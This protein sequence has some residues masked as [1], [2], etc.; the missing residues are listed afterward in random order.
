MF[1]FIIVFLLNI[2]FKKEKNKRWFV[3]SSLS[4]LVLLLLFSASLL[5]VMIVIRFSL[6]RSFSWLM[7]RICL[8]LEAN[9]IICY[10]LI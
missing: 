7:S 3:L 8:H 9:A 1:L 6:A 10:K 2:K 4:L 5:V